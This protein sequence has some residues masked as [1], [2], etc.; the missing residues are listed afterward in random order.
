MTAAYL[1]AEVANEIWGQDA[2]AVLAWGPGRSS[3]VIDGS[4]YRV[5]GK[6]AYAS[7][8][9]HAPWLG[10]H[11]AV[12]TEDGT[13]RRLADASPHI[14][15]V[16]VPAAQAATIESWDVLGLRATG[17]DSFTVDNL[18]I[19]QEYAVAR[20]DPAERRYQAPLYLFPAMSLYAC[21][22][23]GTA[24]G[25]ARSMLDAFKQLASDKTPRLA[26]QVLRDNAVIQ[27]EV[28]HAEAQLGSA[29]A[30]LL[31]ELDAIWNEAVRSNEVTIAQRMRIRLATTHAIH[32]AKQVADSVYDM[33]GATAIF[34]SSPFERRFRDIHTVTQQLQ[35]RKTH[36]QTVGAYMLGLEPDLSVI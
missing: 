23:S 2:Q 28:A 29:R 22:F 17:S 1:Q 14:R 5:S 19:R 21:G 13:P 31:Q 35:G 24:L 27:A 11:A 7:G 6:A 4:G 34:E 26:R 16:L 18:P 10:L 12:V 25:I 3:A 36:F 30:F 9:R 33:A 20:D 32:A 15:T 8:S